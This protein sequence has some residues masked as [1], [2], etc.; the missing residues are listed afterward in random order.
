VKI[1]LYGRLAEAIGPQV[2]LD[3]APGCSV[4]DVRIHLTVSHPDAAEALNRSR[5]FIANSFVADERVVGEAE[6]VEFLP[7]VSGG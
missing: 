3:A 1:L 6:A 2:E 4:G 5:A 7:Q